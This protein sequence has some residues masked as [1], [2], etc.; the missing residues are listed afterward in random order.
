MKSLVRYEFD[1]AIAKVTMDDGKVNVM[2]LVLQAALQKALDRAEADQAVVLLTG[3]PGVFSAG[4]DLPTLR[5]GGPEAKAMVLG[6]FEL[7]NR[8]LSFPRPVIM[9]CHGHAIAMGLFLLLSGDHRVGPEGQ[10]KFQ[11]NEAVIGVTIPNA[12]V[13]I[14]RQR[15]SPGCLARAI[16]L[17][18]TFTPD[19]AVLTGILDEVVPPDDVLAR[20]FEV[21]TLASTLGPEA[22]RIAKLRVRHDTLIALRA[23]I[24]ADD[25]ELA[26]LL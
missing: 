19:N 10:F 11:A 26:A 14:L 16:A 23:G 21:A 1:G 25:A 7:S 13:E 9:A 17:A 15:L 12:A 24:D 4:F 6:G 8:L 18:E 5:A 22:H 3:R 20:A 2:S